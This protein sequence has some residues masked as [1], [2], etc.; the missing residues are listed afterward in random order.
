MPTG[1]GS[2]PVK[3]EHGA[4]YWI[5]KPRSPWGED[6]V[7]KGVLGMLWTSWGSNVEFSP[8]AVGA[9]ALLPEVD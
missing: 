8:A 4:I 6:S 2:G 1:E 5:R 7:Q 3:H 9:G